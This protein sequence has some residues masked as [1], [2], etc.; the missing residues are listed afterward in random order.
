MSFLDKIR[1]KMNTAANKA[2]KV[3][4]KAGKAYAKGRRISTHAAYSTLLEDSDRK[5]TKPVKVPKT[6]VIA[7][8][9]YKLFGSGPKAEADRHALSLKKSK[10]YIVRVSK[11][12]DRYAVYYKLKANKRVKMLN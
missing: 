4:N 2:G 7:G 5:K 10:G 12:G 3:A 1:G 9:Q 6:K 11:I 8:K